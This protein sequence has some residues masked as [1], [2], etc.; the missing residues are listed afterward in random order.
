[1]L[2]LDEINAALA[3]HTV[4]GDGS[5]NV[6]H[7]EPPGSAW[8]ALVSVYPRVGTER[9]TL[10]LT[11]SSNTPRREL[12]VDSAELVGIKPESGEPVAFKKPLGPIGRYGET[13][14]GS[15]IIE[16]VAGG[17]TL[18]LRAIQKQTS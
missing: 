12:G 6:I 4:F 3:E 17:I 7:I 18:E 2:V 9:V 14:R 16:P 13:I 1:M 10:T 8:G 11:V 5:P 15:W